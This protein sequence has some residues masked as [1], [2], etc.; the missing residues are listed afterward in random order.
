MGSASTIPD[1]VSQ[2]AISLS[3]EDL[4]RMPADDLARLDIA[5]VNLLCATGLP[6]N[7]KLNIA[8]C[9]ATI[10]EWTELV[11]RETKKGY[12]RYLRNPDPNKGS[13]A[14][15]RLWVV[16]HTLRTRI[17]VEHIILRRRTATLGAFLR[18]SPVVPISPQP[19][20]SRFSSTA[21]LAQ[22][23]SDRAALFRCLSQRSGDDW[24]I[25]SSSC[26]PCSTSLT[27]G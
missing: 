15:Y 7:E 25:P 17:S 1:V 16:M 9:L 4:L 20:P 23:E 21:S 11:R 2:P 24:G 12:A 19:T 13:D 8:Q 14:V 6:G 18:A 3:L 27:D 26:L 10:D 5:L 22:G